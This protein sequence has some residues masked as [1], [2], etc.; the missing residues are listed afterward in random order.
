MAIFRWILVIGGLVL[1]TYG[2]FSMIK[3]RSILK[4]HQTGQ[5]AV[6]SV[7]SSVLPLGFGFLLFFIPTLLHGMGIM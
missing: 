1:M 2:I 7:L 6:N 5:K 4:G 3:V